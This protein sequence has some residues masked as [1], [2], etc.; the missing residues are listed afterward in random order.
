MVYKCACGCGLNVPYSGNYRKACIPA[1]KRN[2]PRKDVS[3]NMKK[4]RL[5]VKTAAAVAD[6]EYFPFLGTV[7]TLGVFSFLF[8][9]TRAS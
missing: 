5:D 1:G 6:L 9:Q 8:F 2:P 3:D 4:K 7:A